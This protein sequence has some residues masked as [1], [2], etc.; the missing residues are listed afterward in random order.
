MKAETKQFHPS[1][2]GR[3]PRTYKGV[4][5]FFSLAF[6]G[7]WFSS[8][9]KKEE[10]QEVAKAFMLSDTMMSRITLDTVK[11][12]TVRNELTLVGKVVPD[13]NQII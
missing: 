4:V 1:I 12:E 13:E 11:T 2:Y 3:K 8:C 7:L 6:I 10:N 5:Y 9:T